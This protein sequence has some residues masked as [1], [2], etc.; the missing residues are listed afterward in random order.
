[1][2]SQKLWEKILQDSSQSKRHKEGTLILVGRKGCGSRHLISAL[3]KG[4]GSLGRHSMFTSLISPDDPIPVTCP[5]QYS[6]INVKDPSDPHSPKLSKVNIYTLEQPE[7]KDLLE[8]ALNS[9]N[10]DSTLFG[11]VLDWEQPWRFQKDLEMWTDVWNEML[12]KVLSALPVE[13]QDKLIKKVAEYVRLYKEPDSESQERQ[14]VPEGVLEVNLGV[15][16]MIVVCKSDLVFSVDKNR[17]NNEKILNS[18]LRVIREFAVSYGA[19]VFYTSNKINTNNNLNVL[20]EYIVHRIYG[21]R[22]KY[23]PQIISKESIFIPSGWDSPALIN[24]TSYTTDKSLQELLPKVKPRNLP[25]D[26]VKVP[27][28]QEFLAQM[29]EKLLNTS[30]S[31]M[32]PAIRDIK[33]GGDVVVSVSENMQESAPKESQVKLQDFYRML[34][35]KGNKEQK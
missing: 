8:F 25:K 7:L 15:P 22:F 24:E 12:G 13:D 30:K 19:S 5:L 31:N 23:K 35:E 28:D 34:L 21:F 33:I 29:K 9:K 26:E 32:R 14:E 16:V 10:L 18:A 4:P 11:I 17:D 1:M 2:S 6:Y 27:S 20:Y 3:Q